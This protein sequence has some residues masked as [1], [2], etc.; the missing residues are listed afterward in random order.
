MG[1]EGHRADFGQ[2]LAIWGADS[3]P[4]LIF[5]IL[6]PSTARD[7]VGTLVDF[8]F[9]PTTYLLFGADSLLFATLH[10]GSYGIIQREAAIEGLQALKVSSIDYYAALR[11]A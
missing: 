8:L 3:G 6:G 10:E 5:P 9:R 11:N 1:W 7:S 4:F 2:T